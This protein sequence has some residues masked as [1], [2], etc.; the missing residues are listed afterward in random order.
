MV[1]V[2]ASPRSCSG[3]CLTSFM[4]VSGGEHCQEATAGSVGI[5]HH[6]NEHLVPRGHESSG[7]ECPAEAAQALSV[8]MPAV[9]VHVVVA[10]QVVA[11]EIEE[12]EVED[13]DF[14]LWNL[15]ETNHAV[16]TISLL[17][18]TSL[19]HQYESNQRE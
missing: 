12:A 9:N 18:S 15:Q 5:R 2:N 10:A 16:K 19:Y 4:R 1:L 11:F 7:P 3:L 17:P 13:H 14:A 6:L 8:H